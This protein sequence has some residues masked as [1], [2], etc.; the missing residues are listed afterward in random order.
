MS[1][2]A[3]SRDVPVRN[4]FIHFDVFNSSSQ[5]STLRRWH[6]YPTDQL[7]A[8]VE[9][10]VIPECT[11]N[12]APMAETAVSTSSLGQSSD[13]SAGWCHPVNAA[14]DVDSSSPSMSQLA[15]F[16]YYTGFLGDQ[17]ALDVVLP[18]ATFTFTLRRA[19]DVSMGLIPLLVTGE[20]Y[21]AHVVFGGALDSWNRVQDDG[22]SVDRSLL[23][24]DRVLSI[25]GFTSPLAMMAECEFKHLL[26]FAVYRAT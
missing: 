19:D 6:T 8:S 1:M 16:D 18:T 17:L 21:V 4:T 26:T 11:S 7:R 5:A 3:L 20:V 14:S 22:E 23:P 9:V 2:A 15:I 25:N 12:P 10:L 13:V 24:G